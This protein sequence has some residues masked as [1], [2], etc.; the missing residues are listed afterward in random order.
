[1]SD[2]RKMLDSTEIVRGL[3]QSSPLE[4]KRK[5]SE[6]VKNQ[7][8]TV[9]G[10]TWTKGLSPRQSLL[11]LGIDSL[12]A[13]DMKIGLE[14]SLGCKLQ[15]TL[16]FDYPTLESLVTFLAGKIENEIND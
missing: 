12:R 15:T 6:L 3:Q 11:E 5:L 14:T 16:L 2:P 7:M 1:M 10:Q 9:I 13:V 8:E 4:R